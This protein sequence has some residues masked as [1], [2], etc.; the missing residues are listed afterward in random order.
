MAGP[1]IILEQEG[2]AFRIDLPLLIYIHLVISANKLCKAI[3]N[4][5][6]GQL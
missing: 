1:Y 5:L 6:L 4:P 3:D 2:N